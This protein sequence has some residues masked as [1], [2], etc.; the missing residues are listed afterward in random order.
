MATRKKAGKKKS[1]S[2]KKAEKGTGKKKASKKKAPAKKK[3][4]KK[5]PAKKKP[6]KKKAGKKKAKAAKKAA[7]KSVKKKTG[8]TGSKEAKKKP[9]GQKS[10]G[11]KKKGRRRRPPK[12]E[13]TDR[14]ALLLHGLIR[15][16]APTLK[17]VS[18]WGQHMYEGRSL[19]VGVAK[20]KAHVNLV[21]FNAATLPDP[22]RLLEGGG[23]NRSIRLVFPDE[24]P[25]R[26]LVDMVKAAFKADRLR[27]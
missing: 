20:H 1:A 18:K 19:V 23:R 13:E 12:P 22:E 16:S 2:K 10:I 14:L 26:A 6:A 17:L 15:K 11:K 27:A 25:T 8:K 24:I 5:K 3:A 7:K 21:F 9:A 4:A